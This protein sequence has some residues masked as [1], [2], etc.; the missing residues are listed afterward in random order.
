MRKRQEREKRERE[1]K[2][3]IIFTK[4]L[5][6]LLSFLFSLVMCLVYKKSCCSHMI[7]SCDALTLRVLK[8]VKFRLSRNSIKFDW[9]AR[10]HKTILTIK[11]VFSSEI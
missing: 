10:F 4:Y 9:I 2:F 6:S 1:S 3:S 11:S 8:Y 7:I 5:L